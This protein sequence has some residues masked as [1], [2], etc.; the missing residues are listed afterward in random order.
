MELV[1]LCVTC[2]AGYTG[3][4][5]EITMDDCL[6]NFYGESGQ[7][8][9]EVDSFDCMCVS[10]FMWKLAICFGD[11]LGI[12]Y[13]GNREVIPSHPESIGSLCCYISYI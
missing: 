2:D 1:P 10:G 13:S 7:L 5:C 12:N 6:L 3:E 4:N 11:C 8:V 9:D